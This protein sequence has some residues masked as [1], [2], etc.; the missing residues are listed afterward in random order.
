MNTFT[1]FVLPSLC[2]TRMHVNTGLP[3]VISGMH[4]FYLTRSSRG[5]RLPWPEPK[6][7]WAHLLCVLLRFDELV[8]LQHARHG[9]HSDLCKFNGHV[10]QTQGSNHMFMI[11]L[12][13]NLH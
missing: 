13:T 1:L 11:G 8:S 3:R 7:A 12:V 2:I 9:V 5:G 10:A 6:T 4:P